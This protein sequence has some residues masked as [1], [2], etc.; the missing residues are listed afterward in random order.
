[1]YSRFHSWTIRYPESVNM[2]VIMVLSAADLRSSWVLKKWLK[3]NARKI[4][5]REPKLTY[6]ISSTQSVGDEEWEAPKG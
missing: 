6:A 5:L 4:D 1:M 2:P 3:S